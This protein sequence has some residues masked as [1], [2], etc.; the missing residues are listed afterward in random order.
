MTRHKCTAAAL[1]SVFF[2]TSAAAQLTQY[3]AVYAAEYKGRNVGE[4]VFTLE[5]ST[6]SNEYV[7]LSTLQ[8]RGLARLAAPRPVVDRAEFRLEDGMIIPQRFMHE[9]GSRRGEDNHT[10]AFDWARTSATISGDGYTREIPLHEGVQDRGSLQVTLMLLL[11]TGREPDS[12]HVLDEE[13]IDRYTYDSQGR[14]SVS[15][16]L[17]ELETLRYRQQRVGSSRYTL[18]DLAPALD[19]VPA[20]IEQFRDGESQSAFRIEAFERL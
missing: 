10:I 8:A 11:K 1:A 4:S 12:F 18:I 16:S 2:A 20:R 13:S 17:G 5:R 14:S 6:G 15:T 3:T 19:Y 9:D 7:F